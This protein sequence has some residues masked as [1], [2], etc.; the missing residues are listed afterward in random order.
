VTNLKA[1]TDLNFSKRFVECED[2][3]VAFQM[4]KDSAYNYGFIYI[5]S[6][7]GLTL[8]LEGS[9]K[10]S[11]TGR[12]IPSRIDTATI[13]VRL[14][15]NN[16]LVALIPGNRY[17]ELKIKAIPDW[18][19]FY[20]TDTASVEHLYRWGYLYNGWNECAKA[21]TFL[22]KAQKINPKAEGLEVELAFSY[23][24][25][26][27]YDKA[28]VVLQNILATNPTD[29]YVNKE[30][31]YAQL[32]S[33]QIDKAAESCKRA[34]EVCKDTTYNGENCYNLLHQF[35]LRKDKTNFNQWLKQTKKWTSENAVMTES[36]QSMEVELMK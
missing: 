19:K 12:F 9:F 26:S 2:K 32:N 6:Q 33:G 20:K 14:E 17:E 23:N 22:E 11:H 15:P 35:Y 8:N 28:V 31:I 21:L 16:V 1:Q 18:L 29:S 3:W 25:L 34:L 30:F 4:S 7:A 10:I 36:I 5:D 13:K 27:Q 24:C